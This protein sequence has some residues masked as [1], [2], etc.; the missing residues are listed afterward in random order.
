MNIIMTEVSC[1]LKLSQSTDEP[2]I[3]LMCCNNLAHIH[4]LKELQSPVCSSCNA[5]WRRLPCCLCQQ[6]IVDNVSEPNVYSTYE[7]YIY[8]VPFRTKCCGADTHA[9]CYDFLP[10]HCLIC[11]TE[12][13]RE[14]NP[15]FQNRG[16]SDYVYITRSLSRNE[17][18]RRHGTH[19]FT[20]ADWSSGVIIDY[21]VPYCR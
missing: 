5:G 10:R 18:H 1:M 6:H 8:G 4:C 16:G 11:G 15:I 2:Y 9:D 21:S 17:E 19:Y 7:N 12:W 20:R 13:D 3:H 14:R